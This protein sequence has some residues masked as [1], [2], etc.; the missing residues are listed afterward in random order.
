[1][2]KQIGVIMGLMRLSAL[3]QKPVRKKIIRQLSLLVVAVLVIGALSSGLNKAPVAEA[4]T[5]AEL[6]ARA[7]R[8]EA[9]IAKNNARAEELHAEATTLKNAIAELDGQISQIAKRIELTTVKLEQLALDLENAQKELERQKGLLRASMRALY[10]RG[11]ASTVELLV[12][13]DSFSEFMD[14]QEYLDKLKGAIQ[15]SANRII[16]LKQRIQEQQVEQKKLLAEQKAA[17]ETLDVT[18]SQRASLLAKTEG[19]ESRY[20]QLVARAKADLAKAEA[21]LAAALSSGSFKTA[22][23]GPVSAGDIIGNVGSTGLS[24][25]PHLHLEVRVGG[26]TRNPSSYIQH[27]PVIPTIINQHYGNRDPI[28]ASG[29]H[30]GI[31]YAPG[32]GAIYAIDNGYLYRGCSDQMLGTSTNPYGYVAIVQHSEGHISVY[33]HMSGGPPACNYNTYY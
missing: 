28:Y 26:S 33:A 22:P 21:A 16:E 4:A 19:Q 24:T 31:D 13:S 29:Y 11:G 25:G 12:A 20:R 32:S 15:D 10:V 9:E 5:A 30:P 6:R 23:V 8:L 17:K 18:R 14:E 27:P 1:M 3:K 7:A 2:L